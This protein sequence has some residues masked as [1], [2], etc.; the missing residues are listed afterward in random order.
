MER[1]FYL[2]AYD[3]GDPKRRLKIAKL[4]ESLGARVQGSVFEAFLTEAELKKVM[5]RAGKIIE[6]GED[7]LRFYQL[8]QACQRTIVILG[9]G[10]ISQ[11]P[12]VIIL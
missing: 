5:Q 6:E 4:M 10:S 8:C 2:M 7:S 1:K 3:I 9:R 11:P 12:E